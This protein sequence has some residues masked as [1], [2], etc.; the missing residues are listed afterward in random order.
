MKNIYQLTD[1]ITKILAEKDF[2]GLVK[3]GAP[4]DEYEPEAQRIAFALQKAF[5]TVEEVASVIK[6]A[7]AHM[8][9]CKLLDKQALEL[10][11]EIHDLI[12]YSG[13]W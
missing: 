12:G 2:V 4:I 10:A 3:M 7:F 11:S 13:K 8:L 9:E 5:H 1:D 6:E